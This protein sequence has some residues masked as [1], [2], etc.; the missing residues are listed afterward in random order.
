MT[1]GP[2]YYAIGDVHGEADRLGK[3]HH[4]IRDHHERKYSGRFM[5][6]V[7]LGDFVDRGPDSCGVIDRVIALEHTASQRTDMRVVSLMGNHEKMM[8]DAAM[9]AVGGDDRLLWLMNGGDA[10]IAS[11][12]SAGRAHEDMMIDPD[13]YEWA[14]ALPHIWTAEKG[15]LIFVHAG[16]DPRSYPDDR[17]EGH[18]WTR[19]RYFFKSETWDNPKLED[20]IVV[21]G[22]T[23]TDDRRP[24][25]TGDGRRINVDTGAVYGGP[26]TCVVI[27]DLQEDPV[28][29]YA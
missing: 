21:H 19:S 9:D 22:H 26:L 28:F 6:I 1:Q 8:I 3:L 17:I 15:R 24:D 10:A 4:Y 29:L 2:V 14:C 27:S 16:I 20:A 7:H 12:M 11:Y 18:L 25:V 5:V 13:H 23:P